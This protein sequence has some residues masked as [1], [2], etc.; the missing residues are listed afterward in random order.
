MMEE[1]AGWVASVLTST[2]SA[3]FVRTEGGL[4]L[5]VD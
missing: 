3:G 2:G 4:N 5:N 1:A